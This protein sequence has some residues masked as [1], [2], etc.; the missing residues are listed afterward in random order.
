MR[1]RAPLTEAE[2]V[3]IAQR[4]RAGARLTQLARELGCALATVRKGWRQQRDGRVPRPRGRPRRG[5][6][7]TYPAELVDEA[8]R[9][10]AG[11]PHWGPAN[12]K[13]ALQQDGRFAS[14]RLPSASR[15]AALFAARCRE[16]LQPRRAQAYPNGPVPAAT[17]PHQRWQLDGQERIPLG[18]RELVTVLS[19][20]EPVA[21]LIL[22]SQVIPIGTS[23]RW[24]RVGLRDVQALLRAAFA[25]WGLPREVQTD[26]DPTY[27]GPAKTDCPAPFT[28][29]LAGLGIRHVTS[30]DHRPTD[31]AHIERTHRTLAE[32]GWLD[33]HCASVPELQAVLDECRHAYN[34]AFPAH[35]ADCAGRPPLAAH[36]HAIHSGRPFTPAL[37]W[38]LFDLSRVDA[39]LADFVWTRQVNSAGNIGFFDQQYT[40]G[41]AYLHQ[42]V[43]VRF[44]PET[45]RLHVELANGT[46]LRDHPARGFS[47]EDL[48]GFLPLDTLLTRPWQLALPLLGV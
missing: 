17:Q 21:A 31:Q 7:S 28:L 22:A 18:P 16:A 34:H 24:R 35:A 4:H 19:L 43:S 47:K 13:L 33:A 3:Y 45:R 10:K 9:L 1:N 26:H 41:R 2:R 12:V 23:Q 48:I 11:H 36:P 37:E 14:T 30:R 25:E 32:M 44:V 40:V 46:R 5:P 6:L 27:T 8:V 38:E 15:L 39:Y 20:R 29:W 42:T